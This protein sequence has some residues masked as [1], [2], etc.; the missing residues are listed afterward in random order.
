VAA[1]FTNSSQDPGMWSLEVAEAI[2]SKLP[3]EMKKN[4]TIEGTDHARLNPEAFEDIFIVLNYTA[5]ERAA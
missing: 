4:V 3:S 5:S 2:V 1:P